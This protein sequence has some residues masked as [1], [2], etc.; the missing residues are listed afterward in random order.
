TIPDPSNQKLNWTKPPLTVLIIRKHLDES[1]L[2]PF[3]DLVVWLLET[4]N[5]VVY[6]EHMVLEERILLEDEE[7][8]RIQDRLISFKEGVDDLTDK[9]DFIICLGGDGTLLYVSSLFQVTTFIVR[10][11]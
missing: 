4:K 8:Q 1:V 7:F 3:R 2:I 10:I 5:M 6:V 11:F 9:I